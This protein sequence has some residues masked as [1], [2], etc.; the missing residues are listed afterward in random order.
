MMLGK[1]LK[2]IYI[3]EP[4]LEQPV[5]FQPDHIKLNWI[6]YFKQDRE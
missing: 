3:K 1:K 6:S 4:F 2:K 5:S